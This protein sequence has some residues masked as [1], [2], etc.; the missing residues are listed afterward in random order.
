MPGLDPSTMDRQ[1]S[2]TLPH[3]SIMVTSSQM[4][5]VDSS[6][7][8]SA[9]ISLRSSRAFRSAEQS[10]GSLFHQAHGVVETQWLSSMSMAP[11]TIRIVFST[12]VLR[13][14]FLILS[15]TIQ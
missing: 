10:S 15:S 11:Q 1:T 9:V 13:A 6:Q 8:V 12:I 14:F 2:I 3:G 5:E 7:V 4:A